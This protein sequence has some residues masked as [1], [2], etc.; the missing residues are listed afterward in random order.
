MVADLKKLRKAITLTLN[1]VTRELLTEVEILLFALKASTDDPKK[2]KMLDEAFNRLRNRVFDIGGAET[3]RLHRYLEDW[4]VKQDDQK[5]DWV[6]FGP[7][8]E[9][10]RRSKNDR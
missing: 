4:T 5:L 3:N 9:E 10:G 7:R 2:S 1:N 8:L 6:E